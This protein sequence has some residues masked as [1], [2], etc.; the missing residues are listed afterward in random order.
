MRT[1]ETEPGPE[2]LTVS[3]EH[4]AKQLGIG[5]SLGYDLVRKGV[6]PSIALGGRRV[7]PK[8]AL[9]RMLEDAVNKAL[10]QQPL[11]NDTDEECHNEITGAV[12][13]PLSLTEPEV[14]GKVVSQR[15]KK[16]GS[17]GNSVGLRVKVKTAEMEVNGGLEVLPVAV[18]AC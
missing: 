1:D 18:S 2:V 16:R 13:S 14:P 7:V 15:P 3:V 10:G 11:L 4:A 17:S 5:R 6:L 9:T 12:L 8:A